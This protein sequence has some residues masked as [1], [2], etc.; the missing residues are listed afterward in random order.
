MTLL[1]REHTSSSYA[2]RTWANATEADLTIAIAVDYTTAG[3]KLTKKAATKRGEEHFLELPIEERWVDSA[4][5]LYFRMRDT[6]ALTVNVAGNGIY[7]GSKHGYEQDRLNRRVYNILQIVHAYYPI[8]KII[9]GG[10]TGTDLAGGYAGWKLGIP[11]VM[12]LPKG[13]LMRHEDGKDREHTME[14]VWK[15]CTGEDY[16]AV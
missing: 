16:E 14:E 8:K 4:R 11:T 3:E 13:F 7:T 9:S 1:I 2:P 10:Q 12:T 6:A 5:R 15:M